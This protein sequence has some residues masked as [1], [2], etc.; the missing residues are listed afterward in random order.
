MIIHLKKKK[1]QPTKGLSTPQMRGI[2]KRQK[3]SDESFGILRHS[4]AVC[5]RVFGFEGETRV[6][7][8]YLKTQE[9][10]MI[11]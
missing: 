11:I 8:T 1:K 7:A 9:P 4:Y 2:W 10:N 6:R 3:Q 5:V